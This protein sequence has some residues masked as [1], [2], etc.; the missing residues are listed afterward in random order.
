MSLWTESYKTKLCSLSLKKHN[1]T[2]AKL[3][4]IGHS[5]DRGVR[6]STF[7]FKDKRPNADTA[8]RIQ[9][10]ADN[11][12]EV[13]KNHLLQT[14]ADNR[15]LQQ[16]KP[17]QRLENKTGLPDHLKSGV[18]SLSGYS[19]DDV[20]VHFNSSK[21]AQLQ[22]HAFAQGTDIHLGIRDRKNT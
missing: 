17:I 3:L 19:M 15:S 7:Q 22:A 9:E 11:S 1:K 21:P 8:K 14:K 12:S 2:K 16:K 10:S 5:A 18:E 4:S 6:E 13:K 20:N